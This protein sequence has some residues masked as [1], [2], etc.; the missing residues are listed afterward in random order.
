[1]KQFCDQCVDCHRVKPQ[2]KAK[3][4]IQ[5]I[6]HRG[7]W[8]FV[9]MDHIGKLP[10][11]SRGYTHV[12]VIIDRFTRWVELIPIRG[13]KSEGG[14]KSENTLAKFKKRIVD[15]HGMPR[16]I[17]TDGSTSFQKEVK[18]YAKENN[19]KFR[20]GEAYKH[21]TN[22]MAERVVRTIRE[23]LRLYVQGDKKN[24]DRFL[25]EI[26]ASLN[27]HEAWGPKASPFFLNYGFERNNG[28][29]NMLL[30]APEIPASEEYMELGAEREA[31]HEII[32]EKATAANQETQEVMS[33]RRGESSWLPKV[34]DLV[35]VSR[36]PE[37]ISS[38]LEPLSYG[39]YKVM[40]VDK[41]GNC[42]VG[43]M[44][45]EAHEPQVV[46]TGRLSK[47]RGKEGDEVALLPSEAVDLDLLMTTRERKIK[48]VVRSLRLHFEVDRWLQPERLV[49]L[50]IDIYWTQ[51]GAKGWWAGKVVRYDPIGKS[52]DVKYDAPSADGVDIYPERLLSAAMPRWKIYY[53]KK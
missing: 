9:S 14:L 47:F 53:G 17:L 46:S 23:K 28:V 6:S 35:M 36:P 7:S 31:D 27:S 12:L 38:K 33:K 37:T 22:G 3:R 10:K 50:E 2:I 5:P 25:S 20:N 40:G 1:V 21:D 41:Y 39:P 16:K 15:R 43:S 42:T 48:K 8:A 11:T 24:W 44:N 32:M 45:G 18:A 34:G 51:P 29:A 30:E 4:A 13:D 19:I 26:Q 49:G 52:F